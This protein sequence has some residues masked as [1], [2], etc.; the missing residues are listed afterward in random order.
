LHEGVG[1][2]DLRRHSILCETCFGVPAEQGKVFLAIEQWGETKF[3]MQVGFKGEEFN[4]TNIL[5]NIQ[6]R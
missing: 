3:D 5:S 2:C 4:F 1:E 6:S